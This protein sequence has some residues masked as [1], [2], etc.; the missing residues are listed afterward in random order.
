MNEG[1][2]L[3]RSAEERERIFKRYERGREEGAEIDPWEDPGFE[4]YHATDRYGWAVKALCGGQSG[5]EARYPPRKA[6]VGFV[7]AKTVTSGTGLK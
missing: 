6:G 7:G 4:V 2:L 1:D 5:F 3:K